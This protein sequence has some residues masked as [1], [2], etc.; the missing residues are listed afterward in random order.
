MTRDIPILILAGVALAA[1]AA[2]A[3][4]WRHY[5]PR[6]FWLYA[7]FPLRAAHLYL[8]WARV[9]SGCGLTIKRRRW[10]WSLE[11]VPVAG[12]LSRTADAAMTVA[13]K[14]RVRRVDVEHAPRLGI[15]RPGALGW[16]VRVKLLDG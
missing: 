10:R 1:A 9:A 14:R 6:S 4:A 11:A 2:G 5:Y 3:L 8:T 15:P 12:T 16:R 13:G 7:A